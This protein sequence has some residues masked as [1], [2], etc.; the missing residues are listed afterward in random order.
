VIIRFRIVNTSWG[1]KNRQREADG[2]RGCRVAGMDSCTAYH[3]GE[4]RFTTHDSLHIA[5]AFLI[6]SVKIYINHSYTA[7]F[8]MFVKTI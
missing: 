6:I 1:I 8:N 5:I 3:A 7:D 4:P 2:K